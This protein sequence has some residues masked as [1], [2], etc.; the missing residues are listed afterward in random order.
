MERSA[1][2]G[3]PNVGKG[4]G[5]PRASYPAND[6]GK[7]V[8]PEAKSSGEKAATEQKRNARPN[9]FIITI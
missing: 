8:S 5:S 3:S 2:E 1:D 4:S 7:M 9:P 6:T